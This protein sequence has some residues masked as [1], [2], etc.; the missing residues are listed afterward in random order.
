MGTVLDAGGHP[1]GVVG[2]VGQQGGREGLSD[3]PLPRPRRAVEQ[4]GVAGPPGGRQRR[5]E[6]GRGVGVVFGSGEHYP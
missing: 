3:R 6:D 4:V 2:P 1:G 5:S